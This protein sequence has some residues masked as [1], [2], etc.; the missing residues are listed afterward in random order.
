[1][2]SRRPLHYPSACSPNCGLAGILPSDAMVVVFAGKFINIKRRMDV[3]RAVEL[4]ANE[5]DRIHLLMAGDGPRREDCQRYAME[6][7]VPAS[8]TGFLNQ[9]EIPST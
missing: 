2:R 7:R 6:K 8:F 1:M 4:R 9:Q 5:G 3:V